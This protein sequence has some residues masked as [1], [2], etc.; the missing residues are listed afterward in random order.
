VGGG[1]AA[2]C[3]PGGP[4][5]AGAA[6]GPAVA[7]TA[8]ACAV[9]GVRRV[10]ALRPS[11]PPRPGGLP[12]PLGRTTAGRRLATRLRLAGLALSPEAFVAATA[13]L[14]ACA[15]IA[16]WLVLRRPLLA[17]VPAVA[18]IAAARA[19]LGSAD[20]RH[21][22]RVAAELPAV[23]RLLSTGLGAGLSLRQALVRAARDAPEPAA[24]ELRR[25]VAELSRGA[26]IDEAVETLGARVPDPDLAIMITAILVQRRTGGDLGRALSALAD[27]L[28]ERARLR[29]ELRG[30]T[31]Q[32]RLT[33]WLVAAL[34]IVG[35]LVVELAAPGTLARTLGG[36]AGL[37]LVGVAGVLES[38]GVVAVRRLARVEP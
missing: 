32:A 30:A 4:V 8:A 13:L 37:M 27:R 36:T 28:D 11:R 9:G 15:G 29:R 23:A 26:R 19:V 12:G 34:P 35:G 2:R 25:V 14:A 16:A 1:C 20:R 38:I 5:S 18:V 3:P 22:A 24:G 33:A 6:L 7:A 17:T 10:H 31:A 21:R